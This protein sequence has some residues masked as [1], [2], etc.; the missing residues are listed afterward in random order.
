MEIENLK[1]QVEA[2]RTG[3]ALAAAGKRI[4]SRT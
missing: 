2:L 4:Y 3:E 1:I